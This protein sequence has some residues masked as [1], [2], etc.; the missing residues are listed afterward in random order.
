[1]GRKEKNG[2]EREGGRQAENLNVLGNT[3]GGR[4]D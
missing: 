3:G 2:V 1:M 4:D